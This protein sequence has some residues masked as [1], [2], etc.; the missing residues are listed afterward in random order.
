MIKLF[1]V[2]PDDGRL[3]ATSQSV[4]VDSPVCVTFVSRH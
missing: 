1:R 3:T 2:N 4:K